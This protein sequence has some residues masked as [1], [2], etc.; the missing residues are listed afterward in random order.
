MPPA[1]LD[2]TG[3]EMLHTSTHVYAVIIVACHSNYRK[4]RDMCASLGDFNIH[5]FGKPNGSKAFRK[6]PSN[7]VIVV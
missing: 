1:L 5:R 2:K 4:G 7:G 6:I 3:H